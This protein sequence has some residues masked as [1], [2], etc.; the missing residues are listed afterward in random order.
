VS[1]R[2]FVLA[3]LAVAVALPVA[4]PPAAT[5]ADASR[6]RA[7]VALELGERTGFEYRWEYNVRVRI[8]DRAT[9]RPLPGLRVM[10]T[11]HMSAPGHAMTTFAARIRDTGDG[12]Y[13]GKIAF[14]MPGDWS[15]RVSVRGAAV[16]P[17]LTTFRISLR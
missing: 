3:F 8:R 11:G 2:I 1:G 10:A 14:Y 15:V 9:G 5:G 7:K 4:A 13:A 6:V 17:A 16:L 12:T